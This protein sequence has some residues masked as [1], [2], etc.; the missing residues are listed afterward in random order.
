MANILRV[1]FLFALVLPISA[2]GLKGKLKTPDQ[3]QKMEAKKA[4]EEEKAKDEEVG[5]AS[6]EV[7]QMDKSLTNGKPTETPDSPTPSMPS[8]KK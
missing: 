8:G 4:Q 7:Q 1:I 6:E 3:I 5:Q 2:C